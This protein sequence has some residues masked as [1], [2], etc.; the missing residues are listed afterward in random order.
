[1]FRYCYRSAD[2]ASVQ[3][4]VKARTNK[5]ESLAQLQPFLNTKIGGGIRVYDSQAWECL[6]EWQNA[7]EELDRLNNEPASKE[8]G[9]RSLEHREKVATNRISKFWKGTTDIGKEYVDTLLDR[10][11]DLRTRAKQICSMRAAAMFSGISHRYWRDDNYTGHAIAIVFDREGKGY[12]LNSSKAKN[13]DTI[14]SIKKEKE[15]DE[16]TRIRKNIQSFYSHMVHVQNIFEI[17]VVFNE[18]TIKEIKKVSEKKVVLQVT[19]DSCVV[20]LEKKSIAK[21]KNKAT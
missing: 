11:K 6:Q 2:E 20:A 18:E 14:D 21:K 12:I 5:M 9:K 4:S 3:A 15:E 19:S 1:L 13:V 16:V 17:D 10:T 7:K 8:N